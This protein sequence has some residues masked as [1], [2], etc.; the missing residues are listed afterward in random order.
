MP[1]ITLPL[2]IT[3]SLS[4]SVCKSNFFF[5]N[6]NMIFSNFNGNYSLQFFQ[7]WSWEKYRKVRLCSGFNHNCFY[8]NRTRAKWGAMDV[9]MSDLWEGGLG[10]FCLGSCRLCLMAGLNIYPWLGTGSGSTGS[11]LGRFVF[12]S[13]LGRTLFSSELGRSIFSM[14][15]GILFN[16]RKNKFAPDT[17]Y[18]AKYINFSI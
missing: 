15:M 11:E 6:S 3:L 17:R 8:S 12:S 5:G 1:A 10:P 13:G 2:W 7:W 16:M 4:L 18:S 14:S 9:I